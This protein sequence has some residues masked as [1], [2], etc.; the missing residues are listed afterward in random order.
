MKIPLSTKERGEVNFKLTN[1][2]GTA[3]NGRCVPENP[4]NPIIVNLCARSA[5]IRP[6][7]TIRSQSVICR[8]FSAS[9]AARSLATFCAGVSVDGGDE[10]CGVVKDGL[11]LGMRL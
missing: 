3:S 10:D 6:F 8:L 4:I 1:I 5:H 11:G 7:T 2:S 9:L